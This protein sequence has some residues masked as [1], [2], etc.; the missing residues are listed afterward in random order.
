M[1]SLAQKWIQQYQLEAHPEGGYF[2]ETLKAEESI[3]PTHRLERTLYTSILFCLHDDAVSHFHRLQ[4]DEIWI[5]QA[6]D[7]LEIVCI[8]KSGRLEVIKLGLDDDCV[9]QAV[10]QAG[11]IFGSFVPSHQASLVACIFF[12][13]FFYQEVELF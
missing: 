5:F 4:S 11:I 1:N 3:K 12:S 13:G 8:D 6:G 10:V 9:P 7:P 2:K